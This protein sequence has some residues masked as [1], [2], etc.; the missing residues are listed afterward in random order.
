MATTSSS[1]IRKAGKGESLTVG[2]MVAAFYDEAHRAVT[3]DSEADR[4]ARASLMHAMR[5]RYVRGS[6]RAG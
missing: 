6:K 5:W 1:T 4:L 2:D 3:D